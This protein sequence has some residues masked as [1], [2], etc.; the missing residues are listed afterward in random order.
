MR[1]ETRLFPIKYLFSGIYTGQRV[2]SPSNIFLWF[3][4]SEMRQIWPLI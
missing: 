3:C 4:H 1:P 2:T